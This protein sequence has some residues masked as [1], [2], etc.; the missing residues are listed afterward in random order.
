MRKAL[1]CSVVSVFLI[2]AISS[3]SL[4]QKE[5]RFFKKQGFVFV[6][7]GYTNIN[8]DSISIQSF[9][10]QASE[11]TNSN[12]KVFLDDLQQKGLT[13]AYAKA[14]V[15]SEKW[16]LPNTDMKVFALQYFTNP[17]YNN[18]PVVNITQEGARMY[19]SWLEQKFD[20][21]GYKVKVR[22][23]ELAEWQYA[24]K[25]GNE[26]NIYPWEGS[27]LR[28]KKGVYMANFKTDKLSEDGGYV[29]AISKSYFP[30][31][32]G[33]YN[34]CGNV[35]EWLSDTAM[36]KGG[37]FWSD[38]E[39]LKIEAKQEFGNSTSASPFIGFRPVFTYLGKH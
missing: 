9:Y 23:P 15:F 31:E 38:A 10:I 1:L 18:Y 11:V 12:Y 7:S 22:L 2:T 4:A 14:Q 29:M 36:S 8:G 16:N 35:T 26:N 5:T 24:A 37:N 25:G 39:Y 34:M 21:A 3:F 32:F 30:N 20:S 19:C 6:P 27:S 33:I 28:N 17:S 13:E